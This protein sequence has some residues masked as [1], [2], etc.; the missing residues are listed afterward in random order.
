MLNTD[1]LLT[2]SLTAESI[3]N[4]KTLFAVDEANVEKLI[5][6]A[7]AEFTAGKLVLSGEST[8]AGSVTVLNGAELNGTYEQTGEKAV[9]AAG[10]DSVVSGAVNVAGGTFTLGQ[11]TSVTGSVTATNGSNVL[12]GDL[13]D[14]KLEGFDR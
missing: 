9:F 6:M 11:N 3:T 12:L 2:G 4:T 8:N 13:K 10:A 5:N 7:D 1:T 14:G